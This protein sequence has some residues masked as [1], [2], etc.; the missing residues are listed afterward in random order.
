VTLFKYNV[1]LLLLETRQVD[2][3]FVHLPA[4]RVFCHMSEQRSGRGG[5]LVCTF[6][7]SNIGVFKVPRLIL[8]LP[9]AMVFAEDSVKDLAEF[10]GR[11]STRSNRL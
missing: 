8:R 11:P 9:F 3:G 5:K 6:D 10:L 1:Q 7:Y 4:D 2:L